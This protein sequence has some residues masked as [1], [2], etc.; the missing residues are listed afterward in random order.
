MI[1]L[2]VYPLK[3]K[4]RVQLFLEWGLTAKTKVFVACI[5]QVK[6]AIIQ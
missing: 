3:I 4:D 1:V 5:N 2:A 6:T